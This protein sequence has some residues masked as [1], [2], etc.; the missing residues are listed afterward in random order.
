MRN[1]T[2]RVS[3]SRTGSRLELVTTSRGFFLAMTPFILAMALTWWPFS[4]ARKVVMTASASVPAAKGT[5]Y[6]SHGR[7][8]N[9]NVDMK[10]YFLAHP[11]ALTP[12]E[13]VYVVWIQAN[14]RSPE[15]QGALLV[16]NNRN[17]EFKA[18]TVYKQFTIFVTAEQSPQVHTPTGQQVLTAQ[19]AE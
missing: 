11:S 10:V 6:I 14:G 13:V 5:V 15:N 3:A 16:G 4:G 19:I 8:K 7:N 9:T 2:R 18:R 17:G 12:P 1:V